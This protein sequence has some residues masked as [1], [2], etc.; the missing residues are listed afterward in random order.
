MFARSQTSKLKILKIQHNFCKESN[1]KAQNIENTAKILQGVKSEIKIFKLFCK[2]SN[3]KSKYSNYFARSQT[4][5]VKILKIQH[6]L[7]NQPLS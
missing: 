6:N 2:E 5:K 3:P 4:S 7:A 1:L